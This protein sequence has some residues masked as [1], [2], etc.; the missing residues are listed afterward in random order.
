MGKKVYMDVCGISP[1]YALTMSCVSSDKRVCKK[2]KKYCIR[3]LLYI[4]YMFENLRIYVQ[5]YTYGFPL[6]VYINLRENRK[7]NCSHIDQ[8]HP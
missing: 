7:D 1:M 2:K 5:L 8:V 6:Y 3:I 4:R